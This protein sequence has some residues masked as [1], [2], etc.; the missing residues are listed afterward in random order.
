MFRRPAERGD[1]P[2]GLEAELSSLALS[3]GPLN[4]ARLYDNLS[5]TSSDC[6]SDQSDVIWRPDGRDSAASD[7]T[8]TGGS[9]DWT[10]PSPRVGR[11]GGYGGHELSALPEDSGRGVAPRSPLSDD[12]GSVVSR[13]SDFVSDDEEYMTAEEGGSVGPPPTVALRRRLCELGDDPGPVTSSTVELYRRRLARLE[14]RTAHFSPE[15]DAALAGAAPPPAPALEGD[16]FGPTGAAVTRRSCFNYLLLDPRVTGRRPDGAQLSLAAFAAAV[17]Y[18]GKGQQSRPLCHLREAA[19]AGPAGSAK[20]AHIRAIWRTG[21]GVAVLSVFHHRPN[22]EA[23]TREAAMI[24]A[25]GLRNL[26]NVR[27]GDYY[28]AAK[29]WPAERRRRLGV[30]LLHRAWRIYGAEGETQLRPEDLGR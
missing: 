27:R 26:T 3:D 9:G 19:E 21:A 7:S 11:C 23:L 16:A 28:G 6:S 25:L 24:D 2:T 10:Q 8:V 15:L 13:W 4:V 29:A 22:A 18:V 1:A 12:A 30:A 5:L 14:A 17:F 20:V